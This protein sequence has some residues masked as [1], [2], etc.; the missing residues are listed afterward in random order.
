M[1]L[2]TIISPLVPAQIRDR[3]RECYYSGIV[4]VDSVTPEE[5]RATIGGKEDC[6]VDLILD[7]R[8]LYVSCTCPAVVEHGRAC[9]HIWATILAV[10]NRNFARNITTPIGLVVEDPDDGFDG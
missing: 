10:E 4:S 3:G 5:V 8:A 1:T 7:K 2:A 6:D 9:K